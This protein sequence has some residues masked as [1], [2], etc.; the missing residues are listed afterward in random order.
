[1]SQPQRFLIARYKVSDPN[2]KSELLIMA[3]W[4]MG[5]TGSPKFLRFVTDT[6]TPPSPLPES[7]TTAIDA[8]S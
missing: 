4:E 3:E 6:I 8:G 7:A 1:M 2:D 5:P